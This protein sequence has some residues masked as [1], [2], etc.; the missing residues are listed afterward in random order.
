[1]GSEHASEKGRLDTTACSSC[2]CQAPSF[3][4]YIC[5][6]FACPRYMQL[7]LHTLPET[8]SDTNGFHIPGRPFSRLIIPLTLFR[9]PSTATKCAKGPPTIAFSAT[10]CAYCTVHYS[11]MLSFAARYNTALDTLLTLQIKPLS[12]PAPS[13]GLISL[14]W[15][16]KFPSN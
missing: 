8:S 5:I 10:A 11:A 6:A 3:G 16:A 4:C 9:S 14:C 1:M 13:P 2:A 15:P 7:Q 12:V